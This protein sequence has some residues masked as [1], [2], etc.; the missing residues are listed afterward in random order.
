MNRYYAVWA[1]VLFACTARASNEQSLIIS[2]CA[3]NASPWVEQ[4]LDSIF[5]Q[6]YSNFKV[7]YVDDASTDDTSLKV[8]AYINTHH[9]EDK[10]TLITNATRQRKMKNMYTVFHQCPDNAI[11]VQV[12]ADDWLDDATAFAQVNNAHNEEHVWLTYGQFKIY[13]SGQK[14]Y[15][16]PVPD[17]IR[18]QR[19]FRK[20]RFIYTHMRTFRA[21]LVKAIKLQ[22]LMA[23]HVPQYNGKFFPISN[24]NAIY[25]PMLEMAG[26]RF[27]FI[28]SV[29]YVHNHSNPNYGLHIDFELSVDARKDIRSRPMYSVLSEPT[30]TGLETSQKTQA[31]AIILSQANPEGLACLVHSLTTNAT[32]IASITVLYEA[33]N[34]AQLECYQAYAQE[35]PEICCVQCTRKSTYLALKKALNNSTNEYVLIARDRVDL[36]CDL[37]IHACVQ[38]LERTFA[39]GYYLNYAQSKKPFYYKH[40][41]QEMIPSQHIAGNTCAWK[42]N[43]G[44]YA[45]YNNIDMTLLRKNDVLERLATVADPEHKTMQ[46]FFDT[47]HTNQEIDGHMV[48]LLCAQPILKGKRTSITTRAVAKPTLS[49]DMQNFYKGL[50]GII[51]DELSQE[52]MGFIE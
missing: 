19:S 26:S 32:G 1:L 40:I 45:L 14:G 2:V 5:C 13:P 8:Q 33:H 36:V 39:Y 4:N 9:L 46:A 25:F 34:R 41:E 11:I 12:D 51:W 47:W 52:C 35:H 21:W 18:Q 27:A 15:C 16:R 7:I 43:C 49:A 50:T 23:E 42:F 10:L 31:H 48:G 3:Y 44:V 29:L 37:D 30:S 38:E 6:E 17:D 28:P 22:D 20:Y 24:D